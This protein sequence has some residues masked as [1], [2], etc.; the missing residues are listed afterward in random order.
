MNKLLL[1]TTALV[2]ASL[3]AGI[4]SAAEPLKI[5]VS[6]NM[7]Q[8][9]GVINQSTSGNAA[10]GTATATRGMDYANTGLN[11]D[12]EVDFKAVTT[13]DNGLEIEARIELDI[14]DRGN[15]ATNAGPNGVAVDEEWAS[16]GSAKYGKIYAGVKESIN[17]SMHNEA[18]DVGIGYG[19]VDQWIHEPVGMAT[20]GGNGAGTG[21]GGN[22]TWD[23]TSFQNLIDD[24]A[25]VSYITPQFAGFQVGVSFAPN[26][27]GNTGGAGTIGP[28]NRATHQSDAWDATLAYKRTVGGFTIGADAGVG[29]AQGSKFGQSGVTTTAQVWNTGLKMSYAG[30]TLGGA[31][32]GYN[33][34]LTSASRSTT[35]G[36]G[37]PTSLDG[38][39]WNAGL[40]YA[41]GP[42]AT[43][44]LY[45][46]EQHRGLIGN[47]TNQ[48]STGIRKQEEFDTYMLSGKYALGPGI[49]AKATGFYAEYNGRDYGVGADNKT[50]G[51]GLVT[52]LDLSF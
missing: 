30:F 17:K 41:N 4:A 28:A 22:N 19:D 6:G 37:R 18:V 15:G 36:A 26:G 39:A 14:L 52:G 48:L 49:D 11:S 5:G 3:I 43:S 2:A 45:Y 47:E 13:L 12:T 42:W 1:G 29:G 51:V 16:I 38:N 25:S 33:D 32:F 9:F 44:V 40:S 7:K 34:N 20:F 31:F 24:S 21:T 10:S 8:W 27:Q 35:T 50:T 23:D 46:H